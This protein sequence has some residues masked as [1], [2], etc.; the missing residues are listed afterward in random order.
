MLLRRRR[1]W[2]TLNYAYF[3]IF[4]GHYNAVLIVHR[5]ELFRTEHFPSRYYVN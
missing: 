5:N 2:R 1:Y 4:G 3:P